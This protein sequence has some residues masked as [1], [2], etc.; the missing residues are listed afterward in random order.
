MKQRKSS[1]LLVLI[2]FFTFLSTAWIGKL[3]NS[4]AFDDYALLAQSY[5]NEYRELICVFPMMPFQGKSFSAVLLKILYDLFGLNYQ[6]YH[7]AVMVLHLINVFL[8]YKVAMLLFGTDEEEENSYCAVI[9]AA[10]FGIYAPSIMALSSVSAIADVQCCLFTLLSMIYYL[11]ARHSESYEGFYGIV[12]VLCYYLSLGC[13]EI[14]FVL[15]VLFVLYEIN[16]AILK[17]RKVKIDILLLAHLVVMFIFAAIFFFGGGDKIPADNP[18]DRSFSSIILMENETRL[19][20]YIPSI[21]IGIGIALFIREILKKIKKP[22]LFDVSIILIV[23][24]W[25]SYFLPG[26]VQYRID[27]LNKCEN[28][29]KQLESLKQI[30]TPIPSST[31]YIKG[32]Y[33]EYNIY[34]Y[35]PG[36]SVKIIFDEEDYK[37]E[38]VD[39]F[40]ENP[41]VP[42]AFWEFDGVNTHE[43]MRNMPVVSTEP[44][45]VSVHPEKIELDKAN[46]AVFIGVVTEKLY[47]GLVIQVNNQEYE[48]T[49]G[50]EFI[51]AAIPVDILIDDIEVVVIN[52]ET[53]E[54]SEPYM[55]EVE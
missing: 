39:K 12:S 54:I 10:V 9:A 36:D 5:F 28:N 4:L 35:G 32:I 34:H 53:G 48:T 43:I 19:Y 2:F 33:D 26:Q 51:S 21:Y 17:K 11:K 41:V 42:Y 16:E 1:T 6:M 40:P 29:R 44:K 25:L 18:Y 24:L 50:N 23:L 7:I 14:S 52:K 49:I 3:E 38:L 45:I 27:W 15:P 30:D 8:I 47:E 55:V 22:I 13:K 20:L 37:M 31:I 46:E